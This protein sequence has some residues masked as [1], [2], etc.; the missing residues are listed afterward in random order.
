[1]DELGLLVMPECVTS[2]AVKVQL[3]AVLLVT[4]NP[5]VPAVNAA[6]AGK[7]A[8]ASVL[9]MATGSLV[10]IRFQ[11]TSTALTVTVK[12]EPA[13][14]VEGVPFLPAGVPGAAGC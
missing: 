12:P 8:L 4:L 14:W 1:M 7:P 3:P 10:P 13:V 5:L 11:F 9:V 6:L 2:E